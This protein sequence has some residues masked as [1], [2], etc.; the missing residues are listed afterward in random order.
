[1]THRCVD[2][3]VE[4][5]H[6]YRCE[7]THRRSYSL[8]A[9][10][11]GEVHGLFSWVKGRSGS[12]GSRAPSR[13]DAP[14]ALGRALQWHG[15]CVFGQAALSPLFPALSSGLSRTRQ[16]SEGQRRVAQF[17]GGARSYGTYEQRRE[18]ANAYE[19]QRGNA[20]EQRRNCTN[21]TMRTLRTTNRE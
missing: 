2:F 9:Q 11:A 20:Y 6:L 1:M 18:R 17:A 5:Y 7:S 12:G 21:G 4:R 8:W 10:R 19:Q 15:M 16:V 14:G 13:C 3:T